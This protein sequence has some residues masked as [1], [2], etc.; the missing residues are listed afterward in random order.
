MVGNKKLMLSVSR[1]LSLI[2]LL[3]AGF[4][5]YYILIRHPITTD[6]IYFWNYSHLYFHQ[7]AAVS[8]AVFGALLALGCAG[9]FKSIAQ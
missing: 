3:L 5:A 8:A 9:V 7:E 2:L 4:S 6:P 1:L